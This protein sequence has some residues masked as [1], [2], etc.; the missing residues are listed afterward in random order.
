M[1][2]FQKVIKYA[3]IGFAIFLTVT[4]LSGIIGVFSGVAY[5][6]SGEEVST[7]E[8]SKDFNNVERLNINH[9]V[10]KLNVRP[11]SGFKVEASNV[12]DRFRAE[13]VNGTLIIDEPDF[14]RRFLWF[15]FGTSRE[16]SVI[17]VY[18]PEDF[19]AKRIEI[20]SGAGNVN[21]ENLTTDYLKIN[22]GVGEIYGKNLTAMRVDADGGVGEMKL[23]DVNFTD[24]DFSSGVG[25]ID[26]EGMI[27]GKADFEC[28]IGSV[29]IS[30]KGAR[31]DYALKVN[32]G[33]GNVR[34]NGD[35]VSGE[36]R[37]NF[38]ADNTISIEGGIGDVNIT[39]K[40]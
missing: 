34:I 11:G 21:L 26:I 3:A 23:L 16:K 33:L 17:T 14:M 28:G 29:R 1:N 20:D 39:F 38:K 35:K 10:G 18:V 24:V 15:N 13:V 12:S 4:I 37:D 8:Y 36:Y 6:F 31:D 19:Q 40:R 27:F 5:I 9:K 30:L 2:T 25:S 7:V 32:A 22:A